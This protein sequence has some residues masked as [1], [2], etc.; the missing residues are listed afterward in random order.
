MWFHNKLAWVGAAAAAG[1][2]VLLACGPNFPV[3]LLFSGESAVLGSLTADFTHEV[4]RLLPADKPAFKAVPPSSRW[5]SGVEQQSEEADIADLKAAMGPAATEPIVGAFNVARVKTSAAAIPVGIPAEFDLHLRALLEFKA[6]NKAGAR[7]GWER[8]LAMPAVQRKWRS[9]WAAFML[10]RSYLGEDGAKAVSW[11][12]RTR[13]LASAGFADSLGLAAASLGWEGMAEL[14]R[15]NSSRAVELYLEQLATGDPT[16][17]P[18]LRLVAERLAQKDMMSLAVLAGHAPTRRVITAY[19]VARGGSVTSNPKPVTQAFEGAWLRAL[20]MAGAADVAGADRAAWAAY[21]SGDVKA[22]DRWLAIAPADSGVACWIR[23]KLLLRAGKLDEGAAMLAKASAAFPVDETWD[24][25][26]CGGEECR[27]DSVRPGARALG[28]AGVVLLSRRHYTEALDALL[29]AGFW[30]DAAY[31]GERVLTAEEL[32]AYLD[33]SWPNAKPCSRGDWYGQGQAGAEV[34]AGRMKCLLARRL[35][36]AGR[37]DAA[38]AYMPVSE[39]GILASLAEG[40]RAG[41]DVRRTKAD[42]AKSLWAAAQLMRSHGMELVGTELGPDGAVYG[43]DFTAEVARAKGGAVA[44]SEDELTRAASGRPD[45]DKRF[46]YRYTAARLGWEAAELMPDQD[47]TTALVLCTAGTWLKG[48]DAK[49]ADRFYKALVRRCGK[50]G[51]GAEAEKRRWF[52]VL[53][54]VSK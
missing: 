33:R 50:T 53:P 13:E 47:D 8:L 17:A 44:P 15:G 11:L 29:R 37:F 3:T 26:T 48:P 32:R 49:E 18:S 12:R 24:V 36:R 30:T 27:D 31:V 41:R 45:P 51:L 23:A 4:R 22:A 25:W 6:G 39:R 42:R 16:A 43:G 1:A 52:P 34:Q 21:Q 9:T 38:A 40:L 7:A 2:G 54:D 19:L 5:D 14:E 35:A 10:G 46:H 20:E 28:E